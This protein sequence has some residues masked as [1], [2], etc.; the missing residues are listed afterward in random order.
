MAK[1]LPCPTCGPRGASLPR[2]TAY[3]EGEPY[4]TASWTPG[5][6]CAKCRSQLKITLIEFNRLPEL[7]LEDFER[8][9]KVYKVARLADLAT[10]DLEGAGF[11]KEE[12][13]DL[14]RK[15]LGT[16]MSVDELLGE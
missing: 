8:L 2:S 12:A 5:Y 16:V 14:F 10:K 3:P 7:G 1:H 13:K 6:Q 9:S 15:G 11:K 4:Y